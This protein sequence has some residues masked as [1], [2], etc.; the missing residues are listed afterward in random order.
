MPRGGTNLYL[1]IR[2][3]YA[4]VVSN[5]AKRRTEKPPLSL[6]ETPPAPPTKAEP[7]YATREM[8]EKALKRVIELHGEAFR[9]LA[10]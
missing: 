10:E 5:N 3:G 4:F 2:F 1:S 8:M 9:K 6:K 7:R